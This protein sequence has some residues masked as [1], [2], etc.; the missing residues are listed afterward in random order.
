MRYSVE[1]E[2][3][4]H[5]KWR[6]EICR[7]LILHAAWLSYLSPPG[8]FRRTFTFAAEAKVISPRALCPSLSTT[9]SVLVNRDELPTVKT[10]VSST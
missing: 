8:T 5:S 2:L 1:R 9:I 6:D 4:R 7:N 10:Y 3:I